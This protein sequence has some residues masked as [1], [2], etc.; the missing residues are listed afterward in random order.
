MATLVVPKSPISV[1]FFIHKA[2][3]CNELGVLHQLAMGYAM[4]SH[5]DVGAFLERC[6]FLKSIYENYL[7]VKDEVCTNFSTK[8]VY[9]VCTLVAELGW[10]VSLQ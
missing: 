2:T 5:A 4:G 7:N 3:I 6:N 8:R 9:I 1:I 10:E